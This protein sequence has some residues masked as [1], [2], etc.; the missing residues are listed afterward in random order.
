MTQSALTA[1]AVEMTLTSCLFDDG[2]PSETAYP[3]IE[4]QAILHTFGFRP[5]V[6]ETN[7]PQ[8]S[9]M[10]DELPEP[11]H[12]DTG[13]GWS[14]L[15]ACYDRHETQWTGLHLRMEQLFALGMAIGKVRCLVG[16]EIW[17][18]LPGGMPYYAVLPLRDLSLVQIKVLCKKCVRCGKRSVVTMPKVA[19]DQ[20]DNGR[21][22]FIQQ[23]WPNSSPDDREMLIS[24]TDPTCFNAMFPEEE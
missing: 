4:V 24:G 13:G 9:A 20:W 7:V 23:A 6:L 15:Q 2:Q 3:R 18:S 17:D 22:L 5:D 21:G 11:F 12:L 16:R 10:L 1:D 8:I 14:F 19:Y